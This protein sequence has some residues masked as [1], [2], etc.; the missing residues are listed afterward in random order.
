MILSFGAVL[1]D[2]VLH[3]AVVWCGDGS[4][5]CRRRAG[6]ARRGEARHES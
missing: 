5:A 6:E 3:A 1:C 2:A 4:V